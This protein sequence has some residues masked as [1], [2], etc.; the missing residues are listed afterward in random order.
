MHNKNNRLKVALIGC[1]A[2][3][4]QFYIAALKKARINVSVCIDL[5]LDRA[6]LFSLRFNAKYGDDYKK[7]LDDFDAAIISLPHFLHFFT[8]YPYQR[9]F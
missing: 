4:E 7:F 6:S 8:Y 5:D 2:V 9:R 3:A 1:G